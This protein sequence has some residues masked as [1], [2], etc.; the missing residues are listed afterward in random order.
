VRREQIEDISPA[1]GD[2]E[3]SAIFCQ[4][5]TAGTARRRES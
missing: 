3:P 5:D 1:W 4:A 2:L